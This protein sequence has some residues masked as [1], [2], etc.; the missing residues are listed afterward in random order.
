MTQ[1]STQCDLQPCPGSLS[2]KSQ[3]LPKC[4]VFGHSCRSIIIIISLTSHS[5]TGTKQTGPDFSIQL[6]KQTIL[7][8]R[9]V[10][11]RQCEGIIFFPRKI[12]LL[13]KLSRKKEFCLCSL[14]CTWN[15]NRMCPWIWWSGLLLKQMDSDKRHEVSV[16]QMLQ[17]MYLSFTAVFAVLIRVIFMRSGLRAG[18]GVWKKRSPKCS[19][20]WHPSW[21]Y[22]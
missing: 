8:L 7:M 6:E 19:S 20:D 3:L 1:E 4:P 2:S 10:R 14:L 11:K 15:K 22:S 16:W 9:F 18:R 17:E 13:E 5:K 12:H 21:T